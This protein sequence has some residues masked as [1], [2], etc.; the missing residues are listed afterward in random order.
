M[1]HVLMTLTAFTL[2]ASH[3]IAAGGADMS[4]LK[5]R[6]MITGQEGCPNTPRGT[7]YTAELNRNLEP[8]AGS[9]LSYVDSNEVHHEIRIS[10]Y[11]KN[12]AC[13]LQLVGMNN[14][15]DTLRRGLRLQSAQ[16]INYCNGGLLWRETAIDGVKPGIEMWLRTDRVRGSN[17]A[18]IDI[19]VR[20]D[21]EKINLDSTVAELLSVGL[22]NT[23]SLKSR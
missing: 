15:S 20:C 5:L 9:D 22:E 19:I 4:Q 1:K 6:E 21:N 14:S 2:L 8:F 11:L 23:I 13:E 16:M 12:S 7:S 17:G 10:Y 3:S 18:G